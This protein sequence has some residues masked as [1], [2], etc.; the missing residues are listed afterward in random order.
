MT[1]RNTKRALEYKGEIEAL[2]QKMQSECA[3]E[4]RKV[5]LVLGIALLPEVAYVC[6][7]CGHSKPTP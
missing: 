2:T 3:H 1:V 5:A 7:V 6:E 4:K